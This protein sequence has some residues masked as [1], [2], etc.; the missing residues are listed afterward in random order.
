[1]REI[2]FHVLSDTPGYLHA[3][4]CVVPTLQTIRITATSLEELQHEARD[5][6]IKHL[7]HSHGAYRVRVRRSKPNPLNASKNSIYETIKSDICE[8][9]WRYTSH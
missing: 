8:G 3:E 1:M 2:V 6:V 9:D 4:A 7:G 5:A